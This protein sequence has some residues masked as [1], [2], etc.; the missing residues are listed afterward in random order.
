MDASSNFH[1]RLNGAKSANSG[2]T[3]TVGNV[4][5]RVVGTAS[6][7]AQNQAT[8]SNTTANGIQVIASHFDSLSS[9]PAGPKASNLP[10]KR[11]QLL[12]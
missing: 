8:L 5:Y 6:N 7:P 3:V 11:N 4:A 1:I 12:Y 2:N 9:K 10:V